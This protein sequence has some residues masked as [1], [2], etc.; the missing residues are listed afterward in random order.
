MNVEHEGMTSDEHGMHGLSNE[1]MDGIDHLY[2][3][4]IQPNTNVKTFPELSLAACM[5]YM[6]NTMRSSRRLADGFFSS[7]NPKILRK[8]IWGGGLLY[9][10]VVLELPHDSRLLIHALSRGNHE[11]KRKEARMMVALRK[12]P[13]KLFISS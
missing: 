9:I 11:R 1:Q 6:R 2:C 13:Q 10:S 12:I 7:F 3:L 5:R 4:T 8:S